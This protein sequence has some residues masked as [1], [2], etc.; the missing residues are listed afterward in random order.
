MA[1]D[2][3]EEGAAGAAEALTV[4][5]TATAFTSGTYTANG[6]VAT[7][8]VFVLEGAQCRYTLDGVHRGHGHRPPD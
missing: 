8:A 6:I 4:S 3:V 7:K 1:I 2:Q 5:N